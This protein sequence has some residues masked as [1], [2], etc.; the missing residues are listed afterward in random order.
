MPLIAKVDN[1]NIDYKWFDY[2]KTQGH[3]VNAFV[4]MPNHVHAIIS[5]TETEQNINNIIGNDKRFMAYD[6]IKSLN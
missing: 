2:L 3:F 5:F 1:Y 6:I 4:I